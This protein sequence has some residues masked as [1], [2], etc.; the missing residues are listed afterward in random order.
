[1]K[2]S[3]AIIAAASFIAGASAL[4]DAFKD[5]EEE[6]REKELGRG[7]IAWERIPGMPKRPSAG[8][9]LA[10]VAKVQNISQRVEFVK[11]QIVKGRR[12][13]RIRQL[14][15]QIVSKKCGGKWCIAERDYQGELR[16]L[17]NY[18]RANVRYVRD[19][20]DRDTFQHPV[21]T[22]EWGGEDCLPV[23]TLL[24]KAPGIFVPVE[25]IELG[26][27]IYDG[28]AWTRV[29]N[30]W[31]KGILPVLSIQLNNGSTLRCTAD[32]RCFFVPRVPCGNKPGK[33]GSEI[34][35][36]AGELEEGDDLLQPA[37]IPFGNI[38]LTEH[39]A[40]FY[41]AFLSEGWVWDHKSIGIAG[42]PDG[43]GLRER[44]IAAAT[45]MGLTFSTDE[46]QIRLGK[47]A[48]EMV[49]GWGTRA[50][51]KQLPHL[52]FDEPT[53]R[54]ILDAMENGDAHKRD[55]SHLPR[56]SKELVYS[57]I[58]QTLALQ[59]RVMQ[60]MLGRSCSVTRVDDHGGLGSHPIYRVQ[61]RLNSDG[62]GKNMKP[63]A[64]VRSIVE[65]PIHQPVYDLET[66]SGRIYLP[67]SD[68][69]V[70]NCDGATI[71]IGSLVQAIGYPFKCRV[72][73]TIYGTDYDHIYGIAGLPPTSP[74]PKWWV[75]LDASVNK[76]AFWEPPKALVK[77]VRD[78]PVT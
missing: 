74:N 70:H 36:K 43:K 47:Q 77:R 15:V 75:P 45:A 21:R 9:P 64:R 63:W 33:F 30:H 31:S 42:V 54:T 35:M 60:R 51:N 3:Q 59:Y 62:S 78:F 10:R 12:D 73:Q 50:S 4:R 69:V 40:V 49:Q 27:V 46:K 48:L 53:I 71:V 13:P 65:E 76:P 8:G 32:H 34:E 38:S 7:P 67:E 11:Q 66:E 6:E 37:K 52:D 55:R 68:V 61:V 25:S 5:G 57:T 39:Q 17:F 2:L 29:T 72:I 58:S 18:T 26:D 23:G 20:V 22:L 1:M 19:P 41:G 56:G 44:V 24:L 16:A 14:A 28:S